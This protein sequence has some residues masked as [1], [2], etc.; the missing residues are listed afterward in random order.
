VPVGHDSG[1]S[2]DH[3]QGRGVGSRLLEAVVGEAAARRHDVIHA[4][5]LVEDAFL[6]RVLCR[7]GPLTVLRDMGVLSVDVR[8][9]SR[10]DRTMPGFIDDTQGG[11]IE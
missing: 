3:W 10:S 11:G 7:M 5:V 9:D 1:I 2:E 4:D 8:I 6:L